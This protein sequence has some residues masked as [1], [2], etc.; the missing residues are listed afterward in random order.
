MPRDI[1][2][3]R[4]CRTTSS[5]MGTHVAT[6]TKR[7]SIEFYINTLTSTGFSI[8][9]F[10]EL[11]IHHTTVATEEEYFEELYPRS[12]VFKCVKRKQHPTMGE[13]Q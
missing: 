11:L 8:E 2:K 1:S 10:H 9:R 6:P 4:T 7:H 13:E 12:M 5:T 3:T